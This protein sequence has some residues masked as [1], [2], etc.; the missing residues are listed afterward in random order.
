MLTT[1][2]DGL[3]TTGQLKVEKEILVFTDEDI[4]KTQELLL[5]YFESYR[6]T[7]PN[8]NTI[9]FDT[10]AGIWATQYLYRLC[11][12]LLL[13][14]LS[15]EEAVS[16]LPKYNGTKTKNE[17]LSV[18]LIFR[19]IPQIFNISKSLTPSDILVKELQ[20]L[21][22]NWSLSLFEIAENIKTESI[23]ANNTLLEIYC[24]RLIEHNFTKG[25]TSEIIKQQILIQLGD[26]QNHFWKKLKEHE[27]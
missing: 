12:S 21:A 20:N 19:F 6:F 18:D 24:N 26:Y 22:T 2:L 27:L 13:R 17:I 15:E 5:A 25:I 14:E 3:F 7:F 8:S 11:Q 9:H 16:I 4:N 1:F 23:E 10:N